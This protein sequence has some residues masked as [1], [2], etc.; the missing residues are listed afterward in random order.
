MQYAIYMRCNSIKAA[1]NTEHI[2]PMLLKSNTSLAQS[3]QH[4]NHQQTWSLVVIIAYIVENQ[5]VQLRG[6]PHHGGM[7]REQFSQEGQAAPLV[8]LCPAGDL[9]QKGLDWVVSPLS[10]CVLLL[11]SLAETF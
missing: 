7:P 2:V 8:S 5:L 1:V 11:F 4:N 9:L 10:S 6:W 3:P